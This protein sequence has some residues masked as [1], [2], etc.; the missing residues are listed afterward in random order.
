MAW[1]T[2]S[3]LPL[4]HLIEWVRRKRDLNGYWDKNRGF[5]AVQMLKFEGGGIGTG[6]Q[7]IVGDIG[8]CGGDGVGTQE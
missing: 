3:C 4:V 2:L 1:I 7:V 6:E 5:P 8:L